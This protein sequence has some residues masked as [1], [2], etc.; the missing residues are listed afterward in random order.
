MVVPAPDMISDADALNAEVERALRRNETTCLG[1]G[2]AFANE[3]DWGRHRCSFTQWVQVVHPVG[4][5]GHRA[6]YVLLPRISTRLEV[7]LAKHRPH[8]TLGLIDLTDPRDFIELT[9]PADSEPVY[10]CPCG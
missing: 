10:R 2:I 4:D 5:H 9:S 6:E 7:W 1:C 3:I 8:C